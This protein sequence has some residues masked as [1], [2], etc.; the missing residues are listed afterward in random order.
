MIFL[1]GLHAVQLFK[2]FR[3]VYKANF[4]GN[5]EWNSY[6][7][8]Y[9]MGSLEKQDITYFLIDEGRLECVLNPT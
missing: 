5:Q 2:A 1:A 4:L 3:Q 6:G 9:S 7:N 8:S